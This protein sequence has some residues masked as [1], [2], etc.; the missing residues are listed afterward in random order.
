LH[1]QSR[2][3][4]PA[5]SPRTTRRGGLK[6]RRTST[7]DNLIEGLAN[8]PPQPR[9]NPRGG[10]PA[11][12]TGAEPA[13]PYRLSPDGA[14]IIVRVGNPLSLDLLGLSDAQRVLHAT[15]GFA[16]GEPPPVDTSF[17]DKIVA[18]ASAATPADAARLGGLRFDPHQYPR[19]GK[20]SLHHLLQ[21][22]LSTPTTPRGGGSSSGGGGGGDGDGKSVIEDFLQVPRPP[23]LNPP[24]CARSSAPFFSRLP[25]RAPTPALSLSLS[26]QHVN[27]KFREATNIPELF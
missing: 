9:P 13:N 25:P 14:S 23:H 1:A 7:I 19:G 4:S 3:T 2:P 21:P 26:L 22:S 6:S 11:G 12:A 16:H 15:Q 18:T 17:M 5:T 8:Q 20:K 10:R 27:A 24:P